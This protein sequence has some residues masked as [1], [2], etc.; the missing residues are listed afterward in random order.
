MVKKK[1][2]NI[3]G[4][5]NYNLSSS[6]NVFFNGGLYDRPG[7]F[8]SIFLD[9]KNEINPDMKMKKSLVMKWVMAIVRQV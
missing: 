2:T 7:N 3:K 9:Y 1:G 8:D 5:L 4:G 6:S